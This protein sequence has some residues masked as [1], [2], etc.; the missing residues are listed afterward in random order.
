LRGTAGRTAPTTVLIQALALALSLAKTTPAV[1][2]RVEG[3]NPRG[4]IQARGWNLLVPL[5]QGA[6]CDGGSGENLERH[7]LVPHQLGL[8]DPKPGTSWEDLNFNVWEGSLPASFDFG[9]IT[10]Q[11][12]D[13]PLWIS[14]AFL[15][16]RLGLPPGALPNPDG[17]DYSALLGFLNDA[18]VP[19][20]PGGRPIPTTHALAAATTYVQN[21][22]GVELPVGI[23]WEGTGAL[24]VWVNNDIVASQSACPS[25]KL[26]C[27]EPAP[28][29][30]PPG[31]SKIAVLSWQGEG[32]WAFRLGIARMGPGAGVLYTDANS[33]LDEIAF[34]GTAERDLTVVGQG[35]PAPLI[36]RRMAAGTGAPG[37]VVTVEIEV[38]SITEPITVT[39]VFPE[40]WT[41]IDTSEGAQVGENTV[42]FP[43]RQEHFLFYRLL[44]FGEV[45]E[46]G[47]VQGLAQRRLDCPVAG[48]SSEIAIG[49]DSILR[50]APGE[51]GPGLFRR[52]DA[53]ADGPLDIS[54][55]VLSLNY[56][57]LGAREPPCLDAADS[58][59]D[60]QVDLA[61]PIWTLGFLFRGGPEPPVPGPKSCGPDPTADGI[62]CEQFGICQ[63]AEVCTAPGARKTAI[64]SRGNNDCIELTAQRA[65]A[66]TFVY[67]TGS[68]EI[69]VSVL[70]DSCICEAGHCKGDMK[71]TVVLKFSGKCA[72]DDLSGFALVSASPPSGATKPLNPQPATPPPNVETV[73]DSSSTT[74]APRAR[75]MGDPVGSG[76]GFENLTEGQTDPQGDPLPKVWQATASDT[77]PCRDGEFLRRFR[78]VDTGGL[79]AYVDVTIRNRETARCVLATTLEI[80]FLEFVPGYDFDAK[81]DPKPGGGFTGLCVMPSRRGV[82]EVHPTARPPSCPGGFMA[83]GPLAGASGEVPTVT[84]TTV[85]RTPA[86]GG[87]VMETRDTGTTRNIA[88]FVSA[89]C[90]DGRGQQPPNAQ[91]YPAAQ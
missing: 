89:D 84:H 32:L 73:L 58:N 68:F 86:P 13:A 11:E 6:G 30:L 9:G 57:F 39:E 28:A 22:S 62:D 40:G 74:A 50:C 20:L 53:N 43:Q 71:V 5:L 4:F 77:V 91:G 47:V 80:Y 35:V 2:Q 83:C 76:N 48:R 33:D 51:V 45:C 26:G 46:E 82:S 3:V 31:V 7:W 85:T 16:G 66:G 29:C 52:G 59:D 1:A 37:A 19:E 41:V 15:E 64:Y 18:V 75:G 38:S 61:D 60:G 65:A 88:K 72:E 27:E 63:D 21:Q 79:E 49:G 23:C 24:Q 12:P 69:D 67:S 8:E 90:H 78:I 87:G 10:G 56:L 25:G 34:L 55:P 54:D 70:P 17:V 44:S 42:T 36:T 81:G 14:N